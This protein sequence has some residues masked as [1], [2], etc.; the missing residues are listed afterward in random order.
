MDLLR[1]DKDS[2]NKYFKLGLETFSL[3]EDLTID[4][5]KSLSLDYGIIYEFNRVYTERIENLSLDLDNTREAIFFGETGEINLYRNEENEFKASLFIDDYD[6]ED[7]IEKKVLLYPRHGE[8]SY[9]KEMLLRKYI[10]YTEDGQAYIYYTRPVKFYF[11]E[12][13]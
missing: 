4:F 13:K 12:G 7:I 3:E 6:E 5:L 8:K 9:A 1:L 10:R 11:K 2:L